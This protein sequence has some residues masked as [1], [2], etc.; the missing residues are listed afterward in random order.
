V[1]TNYW[2]RYGAS[3]IT[4]WFRLFGIDGSVLADWFETISQDGQIINVDSKEI[5]NRF[6]LSNF[7]GQL[8]LHAIGIQGH[9]VIKYALDIYGKDGNDLSCTHDANAWPADLYA[10][11]PA[12]KQNELVT[13]W[14]QNSHPTPIQAN[15]VGL[16]TLGNSDVSL[17]SQEVG[18][19]ATLPVEINGIL[20]GVAWPQQIEVIAG[21]HFVRPRYEIR[22]RSGDTR[23]AHANV[24]RTDLSPDPNI[25]KL[26]ETMGKGFIL[27]API[28]PTDVWRT[29]V[30]PTPMSTC[31]NNLP[32]AVLI[33]N[34]D[35]KEIDRIKLGKL[36]RNHTRFIDLS[37]ELD[38]SSLLDNSYGHCEIIYDFTEGGQAD[39]WLHS[40]F[41]FENKT[42]GNTAETS[43]GA[44]IFNTVLTYRQEPQSYSGPPPGLS[45]R[46]YLRLGD[47][48]L[49][50]LFHLIYPASTEWHS[51]STTAL[52]LFNKEGV[53]VANRKLKIPCG[54][55]YFSTYSNAFSATDRQFAGNDSY[56]II[57]DEH[58]RI[59]GYHGLMHP[60]GGFSLDHMFG[61]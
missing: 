44:H 20:P 28:L 29:I 27:P 57:R 40:L 14:L 9:N 38:I 43:F 21:K 7:S 11:L 5:R 17:I 46:L 51:E 1:T 32:I 41:R 2:S 45:T 12:P 59:F 31:Q 47:P 49:E 39:G 61:F 56:V 35:G 8:F 22:S 33:V 42:T 16:R 13:L 60:D 25:P 6:K 4:L 37:S 3:K 18:P 19:Y 58:C 23:I 53:E 26:T 30:L 54:G 34:P 50:T 24:E 10:G 48:P 36:S 55:S 15:K 52:G